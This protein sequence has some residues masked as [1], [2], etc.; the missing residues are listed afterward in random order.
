MTY[1]K[2]TSAPAVTRPLSIEKRFLEDQRSS[3]NSS[4]NALSEKDTTECHHSSKLFHFE[5]HEHL[6]D[7][8]VTISQ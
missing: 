3:L 8:P 6:G 1:P 5:R 7:K 2:A 4:I